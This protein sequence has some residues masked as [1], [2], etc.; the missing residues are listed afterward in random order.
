MTIT[1]NDLLQTIKHRL[2]RHAAFPLTGPKVQQLNTLIDRFADGGSVLEDDQIELFLNPPAE[3]LN[4][5]VDAAI[6]RD[7][8]GRFIEEQEKA[9]Q[10]LVDEAQAMGLYEMQGNPLD[11][12]VADAA[13]KLAGEMGFA[14]TPVVI[15]LA[16]DAKLLAGDIKS[17]AESHGFSTT[18]GPSRVDQDALSKVLGSTVVGEVDIG[19]GQIEVPSDLADADTAVA[20]VSE[21]PEITNDAE[22]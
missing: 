21:L 19:H 8:L 10:E 17:I 5:E 7:T 15:E 20:E 6:A 12:S 9:M 16:G 3:D 13:Q 22:G 18:P 14:G 4:Q 2:N 1:I 11:R